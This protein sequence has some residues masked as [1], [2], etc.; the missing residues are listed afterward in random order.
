[1]YAACG[2]DNMLRLNSFVTYVKLEYEMMRNITK[3]NQKDAPPRA[4]GGWHFTRNA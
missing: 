1:M 2:K 3:R 4:C